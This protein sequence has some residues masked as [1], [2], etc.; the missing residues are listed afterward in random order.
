[1]EG[2]YREDITDGQRRMIYALTAKLGLE[3]PANMNA[4][5][6]A[7]ASAV[8][9]RMLELEEKRETEKPEKAKQQSAAQ[10]TAP[11]KA[12]ATVW[13]ANEYDRVRLGLAAK[14]AAQQ[15]ISEKQ[16]PSFAVNDYV[17]A[18]IEIYHGIM[19][20][21]SRVRRLHAHSRAMNGNEQE[22]KGEDNEV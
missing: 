21:E 19:V 17:A 11:Q 7:E 16:K 10:A 18:T 2:T 15:L 6:K 22:T 13:V 5:S 3:K 12:Q 9:D 8:I 1:M 4:L 14:L 20:A